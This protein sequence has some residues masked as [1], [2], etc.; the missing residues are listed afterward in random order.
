MITLMPV[1][2]RR[3]GVLPEGSAR[4][5]GGGVKKSVLG[6]VF[7]ASHHLNVVS[8]IRQLWL[9]VSRSLSLLVS[10]F[11]SLYLALSQGY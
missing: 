3:R 6:P 9:R 7:S 5:S 4:Q 8:L 10:L 1:F 11:L 2:G